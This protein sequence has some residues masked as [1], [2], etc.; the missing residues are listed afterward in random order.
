MTGI[1]GFDLM[2]Q[3]VHADPYPTYAWLRETAP[4]YAIQG[5]RPVYAISRHED[6]DRILHDDDPFGRLDGTRTLQTVT[7]TAR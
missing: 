5:P 6:I 3:A 1:S 7:A 4:V 2:D